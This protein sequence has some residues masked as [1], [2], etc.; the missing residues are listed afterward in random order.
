MMSLF[1]V[2]FGYWL[3]DVVYRLIHALVQVAYRVVEFHTLAPGPPLQ[4][5]AAQHH[6]QP[7]HPAGG[8]DREAVRLQAVRH[9]LVPGATSVR[10]SPCRC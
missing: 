3:C 5:G 8:G 4:A 1:S 2:I 10:W 9:Q 6:G 7:L